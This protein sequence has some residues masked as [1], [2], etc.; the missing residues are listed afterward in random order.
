LGNAALRSQMTA[1]RVGL[2]KADVCSQVIKL[3]AVLPG[4]RGPTARALCAQSVW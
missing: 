4:T 2:N 1:Q 3:A